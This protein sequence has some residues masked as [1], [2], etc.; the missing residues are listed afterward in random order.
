MTMEWNAV[1]LAVCDFIVL[2]KFIGVEQSL[3]VFMR[4][5]QNLFL[6]T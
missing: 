3:L 1:H 2:G 5:L 6:K 4:V